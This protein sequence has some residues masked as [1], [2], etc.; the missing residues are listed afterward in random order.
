MAGFTKNRSFAAVDIHYV[1]IHK[2]LLLQQLMLKAMD[3]VA[4]GTVHIK[5]IHLY[6]ASNTEEAFRYMQSGRNLG[7]IVI[8]LSP[9]SIVPVRENVRRISNLPANAL[10][11]ILSAFKHLAIQCQ[12][13]LRRCGWTRW[14]GA[15]YHR[16]DGGKRSDELHCSLTIGTIHQISV[17]SDL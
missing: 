5:P 3:L 13:D 10:K 2:G 12:R 6:A 16:L 17:G 14:L 1:A 15:C 4:A 11:E 8:D 7:R 9:G